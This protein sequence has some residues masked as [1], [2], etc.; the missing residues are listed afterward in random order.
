[1]KS[2]QCDKACCRCGPILFLTRCASR[3][4]KNSPDEAC[5]IV[6][7]PAG[8]D[9]NVTHHYGQNSFKL[10]GLP[11]PRPGTVLG[12][13]GANGIGKSTA[14]NILSGALKPNLGNFKDPAD[15]F[16]IMNYF[17]GSELQTYFHKILENDLK[18]ALKVQLDQEYIRTIVGRKVGDLLQERDERNKWP[19][20]AKE[21][22][23]DHVLDREVQTLS[24]GELQRFA[25]CCTV[26]Q[27]ADV[28]MFDEASSFLDIKQRM[29]ATDVI[30]SLITEVLCMQV[31]ICCA[32]VRS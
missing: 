13:L 22:E 31:I 10:H 7:L 14:L 18:V 8:M 1:M 29:T 27:D 9:T 5:K 4:A 32:C 21:L 26:C 16:A 2:L 28:Y 11:T 15:W 17:R 19:H 12:L 3:R 23:I 30:R 6:N 20:F 25:I 24:G